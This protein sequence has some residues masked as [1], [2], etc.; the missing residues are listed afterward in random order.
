[1][2]LNDEKGTYIFIDI[3]NIYIGFYNYIMF[4]NKKYKIC[5]PNMDYDTLFKILEKEKNIKKKIIIGSK[6][7]KNI[8]K[9]KNIE[10][11]KKL[12]NKS[13]YEVHFLE[14]VNNKEQGVDELLHNK[15]IETLLYETPGTIIIA[16]GDGKNTEYTENSF[17]KICIQA[18]KNGWDVLI[19]SWKNQISKNYII[20]PE[21]C[22]ILKDDNIKYRFNILYLDSYIEKL[23][24]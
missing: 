17:Y 6:N 12:F 5:N 8:K 4:N 14:R 23:I 22:N 3:S 13:G 19:V 2:S 16:S 18:L 21:L 1:M 9:Y 7:I 20:G 15:I 24:I 11:S 10:N